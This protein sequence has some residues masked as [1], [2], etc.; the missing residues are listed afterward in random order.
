MAE[1]YFI[2]HLQKHPVNIDVSSAGISALVNYPAAEDAKQVMLKQ[3]ID[4]SKHLAR[5]ITTPLAQQ[6][7]L[8]LVMT[9]DHFNVVTRQFPIV[10]GKTFLLG[11]W[12]GMEIP[13]PYMQ[14]HEAFE[15]TY[16]KIALAGQAWRERILECITAG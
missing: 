1:G 5:Q 11:H 12:Q 13:D 3:G 7:D 8:I 10:K 15:K 16:E 9:Q 14:P 4:I 6:A 2:H